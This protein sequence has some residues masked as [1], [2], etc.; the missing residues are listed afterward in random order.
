MKLFQAASGR[1]LLVVVGVVLLAGLV[2]V[3]P[4]WAVEGRGGDQ[5]VVGPDEVIDDDLYVAGGTVTIDGTVKGDVVA[6]GGQIT[7]NGTVEGDLIAAGQAVVIEG[8]VGDDARIA[9]QVLMLGANARVADDLIA[10]GLSVECKTASTAGGDLLFAGAQALLAGSVGEEVMGSMGSLEL[11]GTVGRDVD[12]EVGGDEGAPSFVQFMPS[13][14][15]PMPVVQPGLTLADSARI[16]GKL[17]YES[18]AEGH[19]SSAAQVAGGV[20]REEP[21]VDEE[22]A[23]RAPGPGTVVLNHLRRL[24]TLLLLGLV[25]I[26]AVPAWTRRL[27]DTVQARPAPTFGWGIVAFLALVV[28][29]IAIL[30]VTIILAVIFGRLTLGGLVPLVLGLGL[31]ADATLLLGFL[32]FTGYVAQITMSFLGGRWLLDRV[33]PSWAP[34]RVLPLVVGLILF[35]ILTA[36]PLLGVVI[37][38]IVTLLGLG[39]L[40]I[41]GRTALFPVPAEPSPVS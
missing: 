6:V 20:I 10:A 41:W 4:V 35:V 17:T 21:A 9:G 12:V 7:I 19:I 15:V 11:R 8:T 37:G 26:W 32:I 24:I 39:A 28:V 25:L 38:L 18:A 3:S 1:R 27:A 34:G 23:A 36:I 29:A 22:A 14:P 30:V 16:A 5:V 2:A 40:W 13:P 31:L 33:Q